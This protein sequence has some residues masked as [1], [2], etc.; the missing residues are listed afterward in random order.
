ME[1]T[2]GIYLEDREQLE[3]SVKALKEA[4]EEKMGNE[5]GKIPLIP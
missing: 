5:E 3:I 1:K 4:I 2:P